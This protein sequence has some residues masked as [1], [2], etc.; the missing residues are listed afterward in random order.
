MYDVRDLLKQFGIFIYT[1]NRIGDL[2]IMS[3]ELREL[4]DLKLI[5]IS[6]YQTAQLII[7]KEKGDVNRFK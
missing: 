5:Q 4:Y 2:E 1:G 6:T 7:R 3:D